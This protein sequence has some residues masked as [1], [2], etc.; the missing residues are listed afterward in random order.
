MHRITF[1]ISLIFNGLYLYGQP[2]YS[3]DSIYPVHPLDDYIEV[4]ED[5]SG[6]L[7]LETMLDSSIDFQ[8]LASFSTPLNYQSAYWG[9]LKI[10]SKQSI[11]NW[12]L[13]FQEPRIGSP[14]WVLGNGK[15]D[16]YC[17][18]SDALQWVKKTGTNYTA[19]EKDLASRWN[20][21]RITLDLP[22]GDTT[23]LL[24]RI[25]SNSFGYP[26]FFNVHIR[27]PRHS[28][29]FPLFQDA[30]FFRNFLMG[31]L[32]IAFLYHL[33][34]FIYLREKVYQWFSLWLFLTVIAN[35]ISADVGILSEFIIRNKPGLLFPLWTATANCIWFSF[36]FFG[37]AFVGTHSKY[38]GIDKVILFLVALLSVELI[39]NIILIL[40][41]ITPP[42][43][44]NPGIHYLLL[45]IFNLIGLVIAIILASLKDPLAKYFGIGAIFATLAPILGGLWS[46]GLIQLPF[47]PFVWGIFLQIIAY[48]FGLAFR[49]QIKDREFRKTQLDLVNAEKENLEAQRIKDMDEIKSQFFANISHE[50]RT[51][52]SLIKAPLEKSK[53]TDDNARIFTED[54]FNLIKRNTKRLENLVNQLLELSRLESGQM[55][56][57][58]G[59]RDV[60]TF[61]N[62]LATDF[63]D[64]ATA[65]EKK[66]QI[67]IPN[68]PLEVYFDKDK[69]YKI[70]QNILSN[71][72]KY[73]GKG[74]TVIFKT[75]M[76]H[77]NLFFEIHDTGKGI[78]EEELDKIFDRFYR[79]ERHEDHGSGI[80]LALT[81]ELVTLHN[82]SI[83]VSSEKSQGTT[84]KIRIPHILSKLP[85]NSFLEDLSHV[86][87]NHLEE[88][89]NGNNT[90][91]RSELP[92]ILIV[93]DNRDLR[94]FIA[95][96]LSEK[97]QVLIS[98]NGADGETLALE[99]IPNLIVSDV[100]MPQMD[101][102]ELCH[103]LKT[104]VK[105]SHIPVILLT[106]K[107]G[108]ESKMT[109]LKYGADAYM[110]KPF[111]GE[112]LEIRIANLLTLREKIWE[113]LRSTK[114]A[115]LPELDLSTIDN[116]F[117]QLVI[118]VIED[119]LAN[120]SF[121]V[122]QLAQAV[123]FSRSQLH[124]KTKA[125]LNQSPNRM[126]RR[127]RLERARLYLEEKSMTVS[128][129]AYAVGY[130]SLSY[131]SK[132]F[133]EEFGKLPSE[134]D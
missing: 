112:E 3:F 4:I 129:A 23:T 78:K 68:G 81:K 115:L 19:N 101:G 59:K 80:G 2:I 7:T 108:S 89:Y 14:G 56:L 57:K 83:E 52:L 58:L 5:K 97:Y 90:E 53:R 134:I 95:D 64:I 100:M 39:V 44:Q 37:R 26:P 22:S 126:I 12:Q 9:K 28:D 51:P 85:Q 74:D 99:H 107:V 130:S 49:Q 72:F 41:D 10:A 93:E 92:V 46:Q 124:R 120:E 54:H 17:F 34:L 60:S 71:A 73:S 31:V 6:N 16:V 123:G 132:S 66:Y 38:P 106:A 109:G 91:T 127:I 67:K 105:T 128:E 42:S 33:L 79:I 82:G 98:D 40:T 29:Y 117:F 55:T 69:L 70:L 21:N 24:I 84:F 25:E 116:R 62:S 118:S 121:S 96:M 1:I 36:W 45:S 77:E 48:S 133:K 32:F 111:K 94:E 63:N 119:N 8:S 110:T 103:R 11:S 122:N 30:S 20:L 75:T 104:N 114:T 27:S 88:A 131:F 102:F 61:L 50:F 86:E 35:S 18:S 87:K 15:V 113:Q 125:L 76:D 47:D 13:H 65:E 43:S